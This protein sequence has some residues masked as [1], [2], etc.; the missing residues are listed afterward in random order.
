MRTNRFLRAFTL[1]AAL[2]GLFGTG[3]ESFAQK[4][5]KT[6]GIM[7]GM[8]TYNSGGFSQL[9]FQYTFGNHLRIAPDMGYVFRN[10]GKS[11]FFMDLDL[12]LPF[13]LGR[14]VNIYPLA[15]LTFNNWSWKGGGHESRLGMNFGAGL[16]IYLTRNLKLNLQGKYSMM[17]DTGGGFVGLGL[18]YIF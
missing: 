13:R 18:G 8:A 15:G 1:C 3:A 5:E 16:D 4:G 14:G 7:G 9:Y 11:A 10:E 6:L 17:N 12:Q 2:F